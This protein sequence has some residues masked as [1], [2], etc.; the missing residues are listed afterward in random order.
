VL[1]EPNTEGL[2]VQ[3]EYLRS[4]GIGRAFLRIE[5]GGSQTP[6]I[7]ETVKSKKHFIY[8]DGKNIFKYAVSN[9]ADA[10]EEIM[11]RN[12]LTN[13][14]VN[15]LISHQAN[16]RIIDATANR[17]GIIEEKVLMNIQ[18]YGNTTVATIP[19]I[20]SDYE[21]KLKKEENI[22][23]TAFGAGFTWGAMFLK[24]GYNS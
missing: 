1:L 2:E 23:F 16:K 4:N 18:R 20:L 15:Y 13:F 9:M 8:Q 10:S 12:N 3:D 19:L 11:K 17:M 6:T 21:S 7:L 22:I 14:D 24:W 5:S